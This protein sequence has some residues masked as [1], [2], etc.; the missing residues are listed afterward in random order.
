MVL[1]IIKEH[2]MPIKVITALTAALAIMATQIYCSTATVENVAT[3]TSALQL[4]YGAYQII[5]ENKND[6]AKAGTLFTE[7]CVTNREQLA[8][9]FNKLQTLLGNKKQ[10]TP[11]QIEL[12]GTT[13]NKTREL[14]ANPDVK[15]VMSTAAFL[16]NAKQGLDIMSK[17]KLPQQ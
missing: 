11:E 13:V 4:Q 7:Y 16:K 9:S 15:K 5:K 10:L 2:P 12:V 17:F 3:I 6:P 1:T 8:S 14:I